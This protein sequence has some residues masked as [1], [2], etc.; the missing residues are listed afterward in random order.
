MRTSEITL[1]EALRPAGYRTAIIGKWH[2]G[3]VYPF[4]PHAQGFDD[5]IGFRT[6]HWT[7]Y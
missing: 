6:G 3:E 5:F 7:E 1:A 4:V 2:L